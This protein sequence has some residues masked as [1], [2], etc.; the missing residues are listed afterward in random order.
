[1]IDY[2]RFLWALETRD[3]SWSEF[4]LS[5]LSVVEACL[6]VTGMPR[7]CGLLFIASSRFT[8]ASPGFVFLS[9]TNFAFD[10]KHN[11]SH[12]EIHGRQSVSDTNTHTIP[13]IQ[14]RF[15]R[16]FNLDSRTL[17]FDIS[18]SL[19]PVCMREAACGPKKS[20]DLDD[21]Q[22]PTMH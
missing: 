19:I 6:V 11:T 16:D 3:G 22:N 1:M 20:N 10:E 18:L 17:H 12:S 9:D 5:S 13:P 8:R 14:Q 21:L 2:R 7:C 4:F 15:I